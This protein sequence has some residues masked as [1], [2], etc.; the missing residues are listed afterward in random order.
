MQSAE[1]RVDETA[2]NRRSGAVARGAYVPLGRCGEH[3]AALD[4]VTFDVAEKHTVPAIL[5]NH[6]VPLHALARHGLDHMAILDEFER[7]T[8]GRE[9]TLERPDHHDPSVDDREHVDDRHLE[10]VLGHVA[11]VADGIPMCR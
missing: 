6:H 1:E 4:L 8:S 7:V 10:R 3:L 5:F 2:S 11:I 9:V